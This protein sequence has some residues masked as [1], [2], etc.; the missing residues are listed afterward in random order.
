MR[1]PAEV[2]HGRCWLLLSAVEQ[3]STVTGR[4][5][6]PLREGPGTLPREEGLLPLLCHVCSHQVGD[7]LQGGQSA[8]V[9]TSYT[10]RNAGEENR[11][12]GRANPCLEIFLGTQPNLPTVDIRDEVKLFSWYPLC[13]SGQWGLHAKTIVL[14]TYLFLYSAFSVQGAGAS[15]LPF[16]V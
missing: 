10:G 4:T 8:A 16:Y 6:L 12:P 2:A 3:L 15:S 1:S 13:Q 9:E 7:S 11:Y 14:L 5:M